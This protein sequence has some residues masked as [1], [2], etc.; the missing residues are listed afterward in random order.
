MIMAINFLM[1][2]TMKRNIFN[3]IF[4]LTAGLILFSSCEK[5]EE[6][7]NQNVRLFR[8]VELSTDF[9]GT[10]VTITWLPIKGAQSYELELSRDSL[11]FENVVETFSGITE[12]RVTIPDLAGGNRYSVR[13]KALAQEEQFNSEFAELTFV[14]PTENI[15]YQV[16]GED[17]GANEILLKW[18][19]SK[20]VTHIVMT[21]ETGSSLQFEITEEEKAAGEKRIEGLV[22]ETVYTAEI[23]NNDIQRGSVA[24][25]TLI[26]IE[27]AY[28]VYPEDDLREILET[29]GQGVFVLMPGDYTASSG[30]VT[31]TGS[32]SLK[33]FNAADKPKIH[34]LIDI[35]GPGTYNFQDI[36]F[37]GFTVDETGNL[38][39]TERESYVLRINPNTTADA[40]TMKNC[41][42]KNYDRS[43][44]RGTSGGSV[45]I[46]TVDGCYVE[47][48]TSG[49]NEFMD[50]RSCAVNEIYITN[51][52]FT[53]SANTRHFLRCDAVA[54]VENQVINIEN[55]TFYKVATPAN[56]VL[57]IRTLNNQVTLTNC[58]FSEMS[59]AEY[60]IQEPA[61]GFPVIDYNF[62]HNG[63]NLAES[64]FNGSNNIV[65]N[66]ASPFAGDAEAG[67]FSIDFN[68]P[69]RNSGEN[70]GPMG[71]PR[72]ID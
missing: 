70:G 42:V 68:S 53:K 22:G 21:P 24:F 43:L 31:V 10:T 25:K 57:Y 8:P 69:I 34:L 39:E 72:W 1:M 56:R 41:I 49:N 44:I 18:D 47:D 45:N 52:T 58:V 5:E 15:I 65:D 59:E 16:A 64:E 30:A 71:D 6:E 38:S 60:V 63:V 4:I 28:V 67:D 17:I 62:Y 12:S 32:T 66:T 11:L 29:E 51:S 50:F 26:D 36:E 2:N 48:V 37:S 20:V 23:Y 7:V 14:T 35:D 27:D 13:I 40:I 54:G 46:V 3:F 55:C 61:L 33:A 9:D 19:P